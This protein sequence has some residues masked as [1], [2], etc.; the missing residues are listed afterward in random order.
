MSLGK[1]QKQQLKT[2]LFKLKI[3]ASRKG[4]QIGKLCMNTTHKKKKLFKLKI[5]VL[6]KVIRLVLNYACCLIQLPE[7]VTFTKFDSRKIDLSSSP[8]LFVHH[9]QI[10]ISA[11]LRNVAS[12][13]SKQMCYKLWFESNCRCEFSLLYTLFTFGTLKMTDFLF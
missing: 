5:F 8:G 3:F 7:L 10:R 6:R 13:P 11:F 1:K 2:K 9:Q 4:H 12:Q